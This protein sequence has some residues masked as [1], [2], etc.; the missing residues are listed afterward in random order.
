FLGDSPLGTLSLVL[1]DDPPRPRSL[2]AAVDRDLEV[3]C[4][5]CLEK[6]PAR[7]Y[8]SADA[9]ADDLE[10]WLRGEPI[11]ARPWGLW[12]RGRKWARRRPAAAMLAAV[13]TLSALLLL[14]GLVVGLVMLSDRQ[15]KTEGALS[16]RSAALAERDRT[17]DELGQKQKETEE[18]LKK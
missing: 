15:A 3:I 13:S 12:E 14:G 4:L 7:R 8:A 11:L 9:L 6:D 10:R 2:N 5:K 18:A 1:H 16:A 17:L